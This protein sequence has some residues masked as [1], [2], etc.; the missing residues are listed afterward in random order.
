[1]AIRQIRITRL[2]Q[3]ALPLLLCLVALSWIGFYLL[4]PT[5][6]K[7]ADEIQ[8]S[9]AA[10]NY[11][12][13]KAFHADLERN[14]DFKRLNT[15]KKNLIVVSHGRS[16]SSLM[17]DIFNH[18]PSVFYMYEPLQTVERIYTKISK[19]GSDTTYR[20]LAQEFLNGVLRC[21]FDQP[22]VLE[23][24]ETY[25][26]KQKHPRVSQAIASPPLCPYKT[27]DPRWDPRLCPPMTSESLG[28]TCKDNYDLTVLKVLI[29]RIPDNTI[30]TILNVCSSMDVDCKIL[31]LMRDPR[32]VIPS[33]QSFGFFKENGD[34]ARQGIRQYSYWRC[35]ETED[36]LEI[37][38][39]LPKSV[40]NRIKLQR[41]ED[42]AFDPVKALS[43]L[44]EF[45]RLPVLES[46]Q[47]WLNE[48]TKQSRAACSEMD[49]EQATCTKDDAWVAANRW[50][51][52]V[53]PH[54]IDIIEFYCGGVMRMMG[55]RLVE[56]SYELLVN[57]TVPLF[58]DNYEAK[59]WFRNKER[60]IEDV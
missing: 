19:T 1:M 15:A 7:Y 10:P 54:N 13:Y 31:F 46:V 48:T 27:T 16:G 30:E 55:Y 59:H 58:S 22:H 42:L 50:R 60:N 29:S 24:L 53:H 40:R 25:Y 28:S 57:K 12:D 49:G 45:A 11:N 14:N 3:K 23:D 34:S 41:Y 26:R 17:G 39:K 44:Y 21:K 47:T 32:A 52:L 2:L 5:M 18:H 43:G 33:S 36:N 38:R 4:G 9:E 8:Q 56:R 51:W 6:P 35:K 37:I 20:S